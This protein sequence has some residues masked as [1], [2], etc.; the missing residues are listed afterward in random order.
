MPL[1]AVGNWSLV[2][3]PAGRVTPPVWIA[4]PVTAL[5]VPAPL[6]R[7]MRGARSRPA[8]VIVVAGALMVMA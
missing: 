7:T 1:A 2:R 8:R 4:A 5:I 6:F 3:L